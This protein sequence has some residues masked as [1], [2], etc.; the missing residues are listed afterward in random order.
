MTQATDIATI[1]PSLSDD[2]PLISFQKRAAASFDG[3]PTKHHEN[4]LYWQP[5]TALQ[6]SLTKPDFTE[7]PAVNSGADI[8][9]I[10]GKIV[11]SKHIEGLEISTNPASI[12]AKHPLSVG[13]ESSAIAQLN[14]VLFK[15]CICLEVTKTITE[16]IRLLNRFDFKA[17]NACGVSRLLVLVNEGVQAQFSI[18]HEQDIPH[19]AASNTFIEYIGLSHSEGHMNHVFESSNAHSFFSNPV[20]LYEKAVCEQVRV[21]KGSALSRQDTELHFHDEHASA[22]LQGVA[23]LCADNKHFNHLRVNH[24]KKDCDCEQNFKHLLTDNALTEFS[25]LVNVKVGAHGTNS[26]QSNQNLLLSDNARVLSRPQLMIDAD[27][28]ECGHGSTIGQLNPEEVHYIRSRGLNEAQAKALL[29]RGF[30]EEIIFKINDD[31]L[32]KELSAYL[33]ERLPNFLNNV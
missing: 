9:L 30:A 28:V 17:S 5:G 26:T 8:E 22:S 13:L 3:F 31:T 32:Q 21:V 18:M 33:D 2:N 6:A 10:N 11:C 29:T 24:H 23:L 4:W 12:L 7:K 14:S 16:P 1:K 19:T 27:D 25:G 20:H 15:H